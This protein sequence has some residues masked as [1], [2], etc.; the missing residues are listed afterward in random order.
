MYFISYS[1]LEWLELKKEYKNLQREAMNNLKKQLQTKSTSNINQEEN[2]ENGQSQVVDTAASKGKSTNQISIEAQEQR[3]G[4]KKLPYEPGVVLKFY[5]Q[6]LD[7]TK[8]DLRVSITFAFFIV[9][10]MQYNLM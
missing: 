3:V 10:A 8:T 2:Q 6:N 9:C 1:R 5:R 7:T 4:V